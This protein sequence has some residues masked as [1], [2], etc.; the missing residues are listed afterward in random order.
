MLIDHYQLDTKTDIPFLE[1]DRLCVG[2]AFDDGIAD[3][4]DQIEKLGPHT[5]AL[6]ASICDASL[7]AIVLHGEFD[8]EFHQVVRHHWTR[9][10]KSSGAVIGQY[11][12]C[13]DWPD[14]THAVNMTWGRPK[15]VLSDA[16]WLLPTESISPF[17]PK[18]SSHLIP[19][20][21]GV[22]F[23]TNCDSDFDAVVV[24]L[25]S[26]RQWWDGYALVLHVGYDLP[27]LRMIAWNYEIHCMELQEY[28]VDE[29]EHCGGQPWEPFGVS[30][31]ARFSPFKKTLF[32]E[33]GTLFT[34]SLD[35][36]WDSLEHHP[37]TNLRTD[38]AHTRVFAFR[39]DAAIGECW[40]EEAARRHSDASPPS[41]WLALKDLHTDLPNPFTDAHVLPPT[42]T[43]KPSDHYLSLWFKTENSVMSR[44]APEVAVAH[45]APFQVVIEATGQEA[46]FLRN[47]CYWRFSQPIEIHVVGIHER[48]S[49]QLGEQ[50][51]VSFYGPTDGEVENQALR[52]FDVMETEV[53]TPFVWLI[54]PEFSP[55]QGATL[56]I[57]P[58]WD[59][60]AVICNRSL[61]K[62][63]VHSPQNIVEPSHSPLRD[64]LREKYRSR[65]DELRNVWIQTLEIGFCLL[66]REQLPT[67]RREIRGI[68]TE[69]R[70]LRLAMSIVQHRLALPVR[71]VALAIR[72]GWL[73]NKSLRS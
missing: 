2:T 53:S 7:D 40:F 51:E 17:E 19:G 62:H 1:S 56:N 28:L 8:Y 10:L 11:Y 24:S 67:I 29:S 34:G 13:P 41:E 6:T 44:I 16:S 60:S 18:L 30:L 72:C 37:V 54:S 20:E 59:T 12:G 21:R 69:I 38:R 3:V 32:V 55:G 70:D 64:L 39:S 52:L 14:T 42:E 33:P 9:K 63:A 26:L 25:A 43:E 65:L 66:P 50:N 48:S 58:S 27:A 5:T 35:A 36:I 45:D 71:E 73:R 68:S 22:V 47:C 46:A 49:G 61:E 31:A 4:A 23:V 15:M 57:E